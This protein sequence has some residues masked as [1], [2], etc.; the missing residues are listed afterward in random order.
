MLTIVAAAVGFAVER[1]AGT[2]P[3]DAAPAEQLETVP[4]RAGTDVLTGLPNRASW[5]DQLVRTLAH[6]ARSHETVSVVVCDA[7][8]APVRDVAECLRA[9]VRAADLLARIGDDEFALLLPGADRDAAVD[10]M[11]RLTA[12]VPARASLSIGIAEWD[13][14]EL[15]DELV[16]RADVRMLQRRRQLREP[17]ATATR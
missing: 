11:D 6:A 10:V 3:G 9:G 2:A 12:S 16:E 17:G 14:R 5:N 13:G 8:D 1:V 7:G 15:A 4:E